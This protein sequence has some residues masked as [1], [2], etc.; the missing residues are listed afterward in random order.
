MDNKAA[1]ESVEEVQGFGEAF[2]RHVRKFLDHR[3]YRK[4][5]T[6]VIDAM[7]DGMT[8]DELRAV[9]AHIGCLVGRHGDAEEHFESVGDF[10][11]FM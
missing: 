8:V 11:D 10:P 1:F 9:G 4:F 7:T 3:H 6:D 5:V 2:E